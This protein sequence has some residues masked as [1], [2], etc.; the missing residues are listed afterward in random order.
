[1]S[2]SYAGRSSGHPQ[3]ILPGLEGYKH[4]DGNIISG[5][6]PKKPERVMLEFTS[7][8]TCPCLAKRLLAGSSF[9]ALC[10]FLVF[11]SHLRV[12]KCISSC[13]FAACFF[14]ALLVCC[15]QQWEQYNTHLQPWLLTL[16]LVGWRTTAPLSV[17]YVVFARFDEV[18]DNCAPSTR[19]TSPM[20]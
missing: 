11:F 13:V 14:N 8:W 19:T 17:T 1:M 5:T 18:P 9:Y 4:I 16:P 10:T 12:Y 2:Y 15:I 20:L 6:P 3:Q 7:C